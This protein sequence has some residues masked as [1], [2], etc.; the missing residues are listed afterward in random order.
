[1]K[2]FKPLGVALIALSIGVGGSAVFAKGHDQGVADGAD[3]VYEPGDLRGGAVA[4]GADDFAGVAADLDADV[5]Y[6][7]DTVRYQ[8]K[9]GTRRVVP[10]VNNRR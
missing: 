10:V 7:R 3:K 4:F 9:A 2:K 6:G 8:A 1:M 5:R